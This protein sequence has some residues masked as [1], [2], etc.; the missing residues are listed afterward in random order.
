ML[1]T[2][3]FCK[4]S[5]FQDIQVQD[6]YCVPFVSST[7]IFFLKIPVKDTYC[8]Q[9]FYLFGTWE[10]LC[11]LI[12]CI[13][14]LLCWSPWWWNT[15]VHQWRI[16]RLTASEVALGGALFVYLLLLDP[17]L[18]TVTLFEV[19]T[20]SFRWPPPMPE[21]GAS[22]WFSCQLLEDVWAVEAGPMTWAWPAWEADCCNW[23]WAWWLLL[24]LDVEEGVK[25]RLE[26]ELLLCEDMTRGT[27]N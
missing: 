21:D 8:A 19:L 16:G 7:F 25:G 6:T 15:A 12:Y 9:D 5:I 13:Y 11:Y 10:Y 14:Y 4:I 17:F 24:R 22:R 23:D 27:W 3:L 20:G 1:F 18:V 2:F 26:N